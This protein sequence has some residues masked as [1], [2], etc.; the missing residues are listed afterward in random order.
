MFSDSDMAPRTSIQNS[1]AQM[2]AIIIEVGMEAIFC[3]RRNRL[4][5]TFRVYQT[6]NPPPSKTIS[7]PV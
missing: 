4:I 6:R 2:L 1:T 5:R 7:V 3:K